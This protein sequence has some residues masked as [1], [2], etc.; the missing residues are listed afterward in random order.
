MSWWQKPGILSA[1]IAVLS[2]LFIATRKGPDQTQQ[3][4]IEA[5]KHRREGE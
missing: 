5:A 2:A 3:E 1:V 4:L